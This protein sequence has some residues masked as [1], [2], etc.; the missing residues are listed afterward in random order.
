MKRR[1]LIAALAAAPTASWL[2]GCGGSVDEGTV[3]LRFVNASTGYASLDLY[4]DSD[5]EIRDVAKATCSDYVNVASDN[6]T[7]SVRSA[8]SGIKLATLDVGFDSDTHYTLIAHGPAGDLTLELLTEDSS[9]GDDGFAK[10]R[11][12]NAAS[13]AGLLDV[14]VGDVGN[15]VAQ[16][17]VLAEKAAIGKATDFVEIGKGH[18]RFAVTK[19]AETADLRLDIP[20]LQLSDGQ[21]ATLVLAPTEG[22]ALVNALLLNETGSA[23]TFANSQARVRLAVSLSSATTASATASCD[24]VTIGTAQA[25]GTVGS[26]VR[27]PAGGA[28]SVSAAGNVIDAPGAAIEAGRDYTLLVRGTVTAAVATLLNDDNRPPSDETQSR[29]RAVHA[30]ARNNDETLSVDVASNRLVSAL[31]FGDVS[32]PV[33]FTP[34]STSTT[35][36][37]T[38]GAA[39]PISATRTL[40]AQSTYTV[41]VL[42][43]NAATTSWVLRQ[44]FVRS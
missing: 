7:A 22:G 28:I 44:D 11:V 1:T 10:V 34:P 43:S 15:G 24:D 4:L 30:S 23:A 32:D 8:N 17:D 35:V 3:K 38:I 39:P 26:Y 6:F 40:A 33:S 37:V 36:S 21:V 42:D 31:A 14:L 41:F 18:Y 19:P 27:V 5:A 2:A 25:A 12:F 16:L 9:E 29:L 20:D 13:D